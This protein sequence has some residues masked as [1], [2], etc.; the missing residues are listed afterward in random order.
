MRQKN[1]KNA[2]MGQ[3][4]AGRMDGESASDLKREQK[5]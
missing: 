4:K 2:W 5:Q 1:N 3:E